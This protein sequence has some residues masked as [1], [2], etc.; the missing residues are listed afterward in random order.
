[1]RGRKGGERVKIAP[2][3][4]LHCVKSAPAD[5]STC[6]K[7]GRGNTDLRRSVFKSNNDFDNDL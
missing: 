4:A 7:L 6:E 3:S 5:K 2:M 1:M